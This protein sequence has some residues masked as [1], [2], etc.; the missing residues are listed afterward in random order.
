MRG[1]DGRFPTREIVGGALEAREALW[2]HVRGVRALVD[3]RGGQRGP[4]TSWRIIADKDRAH[5]WLRAADDYLAVGEPLLACPYVVL[6]LASYNLS[7][8]S[9]E[10]LAERHAAW[11]RRARPAPLLEELV[12]VADWLRALHPWLKAAPIPAAAARAIR[13]RES[14]VVS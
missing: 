11:K 1:K 5:D 14:A 12:R 4:E 13:A 7:L 3:P 6:G 2:P 10:A 9:D 8:L